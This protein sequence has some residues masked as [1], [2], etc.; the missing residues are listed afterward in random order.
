MSTKR[1]H[2]RALFAAFLDLAPTFSGEHLEVWLQPDD[3][4][5]FPDIVATS[6]TGRRVGIEI[7]EW[8]NEEEIHAAKRQERLEEA[9]LAA[10]G[11]QGSNP[12]RNVRYVWLRPAVKIPASERSS[13]RKQL[14]A[15]ILDYDKCW[16]SDELRRTGNR[17]VGDSLATYPVLA[18][19]LSEVKLW[20]ANGKQWE[21]DWITFPARARWFDRE[22]MF[23]PL[24]EIVAAKL[25]H[26][27][28]GRSGFED[29]S[30]LVIYNRAAIYNSPAETPLHSYDDAVAEL[31]QMIGDNRGPFD[32]VLLYI[33]LMPGARVFPVC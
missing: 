5:E 13:F 17:V 6:V 30:L 20:P 31:R 33:A 32:R 2:E 24:R 18:K 8:L 7:A 11:D 4:R 25:A 9:C 10:I 3:E 23:K 27:G 1:E 29:L 15:C 19:Y 28:A 21:R 22:T 14:F 12:T 26:Y 16:S